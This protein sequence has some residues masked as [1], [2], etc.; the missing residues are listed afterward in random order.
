M[1]E[2]VNVLLSGNWQVYDW[3]TT[4]SALMQVKHT[5]SGLA[6]GTVRVGIGEEMFAMTVNSEGVSCSP[7]VDAADLS[8]TPF[9]AHRVIF[10]P[11]RPSDVVGIPDAARVLEA[12]APLPLSFFRADSV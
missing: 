10:G 8:L 3:A 7:R 11:S 6:E 4:L 2:T 12:W 9:Q 1:G 5:T